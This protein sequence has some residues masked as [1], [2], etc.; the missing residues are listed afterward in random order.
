MQHNYKK[1]HIHI[2]LF[3]TD[4]TYVVGTDILLVLTDRKNESVRDKK[5]AHSIK[6]ISY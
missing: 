1:W 2:H 4:R 3:H 6:Q 5:F